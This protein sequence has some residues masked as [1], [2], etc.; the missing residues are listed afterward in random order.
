MLVLNRRRHESIEITVPPSAEPTTVT[1]SVRSISGKST[2][3]GLSAPP[4]VRIHRDNIKV[5]E[6]D[7]G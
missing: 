4:V 7:D 5:K 6:V 2:K 3:L 1:V